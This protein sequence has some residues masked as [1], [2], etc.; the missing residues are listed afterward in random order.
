MKNEN[1]PTTTHWTQE[2]D[3]FL[4]A[5]EIQPPKAVSLVV[6]S[7]VR[8]DLNPIAWLVFWKLAMIH[9]FV[10]TLTLVFC[11]QFG[12]SFTSSMGLMNVLMR[13]G[14]AFC[15]FGC[16]ALFLGVSTLVASLLLRP[17][18]IRVIRRHEVLQLTLLASLSVGVFLC[19]LGGGV[20]AAL[21]GVWL[22]GSIIGGVAT[23]ELGWAI[24]SHLRK[25]LVY[26]D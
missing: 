4:A 2:F 5:D 25:R 15:M 24:R 14:E 12:F 7:K 21:T 8:R 11:P 20:I 13:Y 6:L 3:D 10:G 16:G 17:E 26:G 9:V 1:P 23:L 18:E 22:V 19:V